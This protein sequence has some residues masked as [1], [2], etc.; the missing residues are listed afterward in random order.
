MKELGG[1]GKPA[2]A[3]LLSLSD[4]WPAFA[5]SATLFCR[6]FSFLNRLVFSRESLSSSSPSLPAAIASFIS[7][8]LAQSTLVHPLRSF[9][10]KSYSALGR[11]TS[12]I[13]VGPMCM[14]MVERIGVATFKMFSASSYF[15]SFSKLLVVGIGSDLTAPH[16]KWGVAC[17]LLYY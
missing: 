3:L 17:G 6:C 2:V 7:P 1:S 4:C 10:S 11:P 9:S 13:L 8:S 15:N 5:L 16:N 12:K 14:P